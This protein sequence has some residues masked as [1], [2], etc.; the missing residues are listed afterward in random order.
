MSRSLPSLHTLNLSN[1]G[2]N[3]KDIRSLAKAK[4]QGRLPELKH[5]DI[6]DN[7]RIVGQIENL[8]TNGERW[9][10][11]ITLNVKQD[12]DSDEDFKC[13]VHPVQSGALGE[14]QKLVLST[15]GVGL[16]VPNC[17]SV[18][19]PKLKLLDIHCAHR[20]RSNDPVNVFLKVLEGVE[21]TKFPNLDTVY[22]TLALVSQHYPLY[23]LEGFLEAYGTNSELYEH[24]GQAA[25]T[26]QSLVSTSVP[27]DSY[28]KYILGL[29]RLNSL[30]EESPDE[31]YNV[32]NR[33]VSKFTFVMS[34][35]CSFPDLKT[36][37][38]VLHECIDM[39]PNI[40]NSSRPYAKYLGDVACANV[41]SYF[42]GEPL[43]I[44]ELC[45]GIFDW[46]E[47]SYDL[48]TEDL[49]ALRSLLKGVQTMSNTPLD[50]VEQIRQ[51][52]NAWTQSTIHVEDC[53]RSPLISMTECISTCVHSF[54]SGERLN[55]Q[56]VSILSG[57]L[58]H[59]DRSVTH[60]ER[61]SYE[62]LVDVI[63]CLIE[64]VV[65]KP[66][67]LQA[68]SN[69]LKE[70]I[71]TNSNLPQSIRYFAK[72]C[73]DLFCTGVECSFRKP[74]NL[75]PLAHVLCEWIDKFPNVSS[76]DRA[77]Y[78]SIA[79]ESCKKI[80]SQMNTYFNQLSVLPPS[81]SPNKEPFPVKE[82]TLQWKG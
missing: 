15:N 29:T 66:V 18:K 7:E 41:Y 50:G 11:L 1:C 59:C 56:P 62:A 19:W 4:R 76:K 24:L 9:N 2:L 69:K 38:L 51:T 17:L 72:M 74:W 70:S 25:K 64:S 8:F 53:N 80:Q 10:K 75:E 61:R 32:W 37:C 58:L 40:S 34:D 67:S 78:K 43:D 35:T 44:S 23:T 55:L 65:N 71:E 48:N 30:L 28:V 52:L 3:P 20:R 73:V 26:S 63:C 6:S 36:A 60:T 16:Y 22:V 68:V 81:T 39:S 46:V 14:L 57:D 42:K 13:L 54:F 79:E 27:N 82:K 31:E 12:V 33:F 49:S 45:T 77:N 47:N 5:L 21:T